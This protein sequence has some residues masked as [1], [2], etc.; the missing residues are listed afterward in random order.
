MRNI[1]PDQTHDWNFDYSTLNFVKYQPASFGYSNYV[2]PSDPNLAVVIARGVDPAFAAFVYAL[3]SSDSRA[4]VTHGGFVNDDPEPW[5]NSTENEDWLNYGGADMTLTDTDR[6]FNE[7]EGVNIVFKESVLS[8]GE[9]TCFRTFS[10]LSENF[11]VE[12]PDPL[13]PGGETSSPTPSPSPAACAYFTTMTLTYDSSAALD[14]V[15][16]QSLQDFLFTA[17]GITSGVTIVPAEETTSHTSHSIH[18]AHAPPPSPPA[19]PSVP[20]SPS[21]RPSPPVLPTPV[22]TTHASMGMDS[23]MHKALFVTNLL[24]SI[25]GNC[26]VEPNILA[27]ITPTALS[28]LS[29]QLGVTISAITFTP[30]VSQSCSSLMVSLTSVT[31]PTTTDDTFCQHVSGGIQ[32]GGEQ[33]LNFDL[34]NGN[35]AFD[36][37][38]LAGLTAYAAAHCGLVNKSQFTDELL[39]ALAPHSQLFFNDENVL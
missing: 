5:Y 37:S 12:I 27:L 29:V 7:D 30:F 33:Q 20:A 38:T 34:P 13:P 39:L 2:S 10:G 32:C 26:N 9:K 11:E 22:G 16:L 21:P 19:S 24:I 36:L 35:C 14:L 8:P 3:G 18:T 1:D 15:D 17:A 6:M 23:G 25:V 4:F 31:C 28:N